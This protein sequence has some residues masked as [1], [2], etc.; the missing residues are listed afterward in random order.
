MDYRIIGLSG[1][2]SS[3]ETVR[4]PLFQSLP[5]PVPSFDQTTP[6]HHRLRSRNTISTHKNSDNDIGLQQQLN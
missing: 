2:G 3:R 4:T 5:T 6:Q 1:V